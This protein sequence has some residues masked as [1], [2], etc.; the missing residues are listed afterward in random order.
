MSRVTRAEHRER[1]ML[2]RL[3]SVATGESV[4]LPWREKVT[5]LPGGERNHMLPLTPMEMDRLRAAVAGDRGL[6]PMLLRLLL[7]T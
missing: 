7:L 6:R 2:S 3:E 4:V 5:L 1:L